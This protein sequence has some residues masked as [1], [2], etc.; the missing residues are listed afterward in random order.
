MPGL[1]DASDSAA[2]QPCWASMH[3]ALFKK[4]AMAIFFI[5]SMLLGAELQI[6][7]MFGNT[8]LHSFDKLMMFAIA[9]LCSMRHRHVDFANL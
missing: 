7:N 9:L 6:T 3:F 5:F 8:F 1:L 4:R 2:G